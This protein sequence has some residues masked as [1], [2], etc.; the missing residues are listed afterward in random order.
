VAVP[1]YEKCGYE[2]IGGGFN[3]ADIGLHYVM[4]KSA[5]DFR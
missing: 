5:P 3:I 1:F 4:Y 2:K